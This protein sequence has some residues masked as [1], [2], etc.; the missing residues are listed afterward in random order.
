LTESQKL[1]DVLWTWRYFAR[2]WLDHVV[3][4]KLQTL[5]LAVVSS[6]DG[7]GQVGSRIE[8]MWLTRA[9]QCS[10]SSST[11]QT[12]ISKEAVACIATRVVHP[13]PE[14]AGI[15]MVLL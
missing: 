7:T 4:A 10:V 12:V 5:M 6:A 11:P 3:E 15:F 14:P 9:L 13:G 8:T 1:S 2:H